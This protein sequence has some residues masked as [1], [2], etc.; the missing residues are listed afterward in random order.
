[1]SPFDP[2]CSSCHG[3]G[4]IK[5]P[6]KPRIEHGRIITAWCV[7][8]GCENPLNVFGPALVE[9]RRKV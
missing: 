8:C 7:P 1:M 5:T 4:V 2:G 9:R 6:I 3:T